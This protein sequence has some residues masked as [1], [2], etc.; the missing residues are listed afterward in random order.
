VDVAVDAEGRSLVKLNANAPALDR[1]DQW[2]RFEASLVVH[3]LKSLPAANVVAVDAAVA[4]NDRALL[5]S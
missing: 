5:A 2:Y 3:V 4:G 1:I